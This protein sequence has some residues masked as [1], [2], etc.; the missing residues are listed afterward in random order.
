MADKLGIVAG[1]GSLPAQLIEACRREGREVFVVAIRGHAEAKSLAGARHVWVRLGAPGTALELARREGVRDVVFAGYVRRP[2]RLRDFLRIGVPDGIAWRFLLTERMTILRDSGLLKAVARWA[3]GH[4]GL[5]VV[6][7]QAVDRSLLAVAGT[8][9]RV[10]PDEAA[11]RDIALGID[12]AHAVG[13][14]DKGQGAVVQQGQVLATEDSRGT[15]AMLLRAGAARRSGP[16]GVLV[17][18]TKPGQEMRID[19]PTIGVR[20]IRNAKAAGLRGI[21]V[22]AGAALVL[23]RA[24][25]VAEADAAGL[26]VVGVNVPDG[27]AS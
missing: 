2:R 17:K 10:E 6:G 22:E 26:F 21:A 20:T 18:V 12:A 27:G 13:R 14:A 24:A 15:D 16:G 1:G 3:E 7:V 8:Y 9:G 4:F 19:L 25:L 11:R 5:R 23:D